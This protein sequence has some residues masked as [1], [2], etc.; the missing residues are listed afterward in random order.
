MSGNVVSMKSIWIITCFSSIKR[1]CVVG[2]LV[3]AW[4]FRS[5]MY[6]EPLSLVVMNLTNPW[7]IYPSGH[8]SLSVCVSCSLS[9]MAYLQGESMFCK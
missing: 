9:V 5:M 6:L 2:D 1:V 4:Y 8:G 3:H 7:Y